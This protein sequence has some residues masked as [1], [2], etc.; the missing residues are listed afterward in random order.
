MPSSVAPAPTI[1]LPN[2]VLDVYK[3]AEALDCC[4]ATVRREANRGRLRGTKVG[5]RW[6]FRPEDV[7][8]YLDGETP[9]QAAERHDWDA[10]IRKVVAAAPPLTPGQISALSALFDVTGGAHGTP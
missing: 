4:T 9:A 5:S 2:Q 6:R 10:H 3:V 1:D 8:A 7:A